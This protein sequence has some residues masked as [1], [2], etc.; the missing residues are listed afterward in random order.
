L[1]Q[2]LAGWVFRH[3]QGTI[4]RD[5]SQDRRWVTLPEYTETTGSV[6]AAPLTAG[7]EIIGILL[8]THTSQ[9]HFDQDHLALLSS[10]S[11]QTANALA[12]VQLLVRAQEEQGKLSAVLNGTANAVLAIDGAGNLILANPAAER[13][14]A[15]DANQLLGQPVTS[16]IP[17]QLAQAFDQ[18]DTSGESIAAEIA[19]GQGKTLYVNV[20]LVA[21]VGKVACGPGHHPP[22]RT[23][24]DALGGRAKGAPSYPQHPW[25]VRQSRAH[26][27]YP[28]PGRKAAGA[29]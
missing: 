20:S 25:T 28:C 2:G 11:A 8:L 1:E 19:V 10:I 17:P 7:G 29:S 26:G 6:I 3:Q 9:N 14:L 18:V 21:G 13:A 5:A 23:G 22:Q 12:N 27:S 15:F 24:S 4:M 16:N